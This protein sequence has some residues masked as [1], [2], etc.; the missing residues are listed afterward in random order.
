[1]T[2]SPFKV[3]DKVVIVRSDFVPERIGMVVTITSELK[4]LRFPWSR[5]TRTPAH[6]IDLSGRDG[7]RLAY[8][9]CHLRPYHREANEPA[10]ESTE[11][12]LRDLC[13]GKVSEET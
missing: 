2:T 7:R 12:W 6:F 9:P 11:E 8:P 3:G 4:F 13:H 1:M 10:D 5:D